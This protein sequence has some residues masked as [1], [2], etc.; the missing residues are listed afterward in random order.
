MSASRKGCM[1]ALMVV[2]LKQ[3]RVVFPLS[4]MVVCV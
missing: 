2:N 4:T 3:E 1:S